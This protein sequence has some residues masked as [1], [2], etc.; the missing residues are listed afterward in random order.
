MA[1]TH[2]VPKGTAS[3]AQFAN[4]SVGEIFVMEGNNN[5]VLSVNQ[6]GN[7]C[8][9]ANCYKLLN[10]QGG[11]MEAIATQLLQ[12]V[13]NNFDMIVVWTTFEDAGGGAFY[14]PLKNDTYGLGKCNQGGGQDQIFGCEFDQVGPQIRAQGLIFMNAVE[15]WKYADS[16]Y[17]LN[18]DE[19]DFRS[20]I[21][22][23][24]GQE[25]AH[26]W[27]VGFH[28]NDPRTGRDSRALL[29]RDFS[30]WNLKLDAFASV[31]DGLDWEDTG[32]GA[33]QIVADNDTY[34]PLDLYAM[35]LM[36]SAE[37]PDFFLV[38]NAF[39]QDLRQMY[40]NFGQNFDGNIPNGNDE[41][42]LPPLE[43]VGRPIEAVGDKL[44]V[45]IQ[46]IVESNGVR[47]PD[48]NSSQKTF[49]QAFVLV[50][51][52]G[53]SVAAAAPY[54][55]QLETVR[56]TWEAWFS[57][58]TGG[59]GTMC[60]TLSGECDTPQAEIRD[61]RLADDNGEWARGEEVELFLSLANTGARSILTVSAALGSNGG[62][63][64]SQAGIQLTDIPGNA[65]VE[66][67]TPFRARLDETF[68]C[69][70][71]TV[72]V[73]VTL[74]PVGTDVDGR[75]FTFNVKPCEPVV[76][77]GNGGGGG[78]NPPA[79]GLCACA[80][81]VSG[82]SPWMGVALLGLLVSRRRR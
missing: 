55:A 52:P 81:A 44:N 60:T 31:M 9:G 4:A 74:D 27:L 18:Y 71:S 7:P 20:Q 1:A 25:S 28:I 38:E 45:N 73:R 22:A 51:L 8:T 75:E 54:V 23:T 67:G 78:S 3:T 39:S 72:T 68:D 56:Q 14:A 12:S 61:L 10:N 42:F 82:A 69:A 77:P 79:F 64:I 32:G 26:R 2:K 24:L 30:H 17:Q 76:D 13:G 33:F 48:V 46:M 41:L 62:V 5:L 57:S 15:T 16:Q 63:D 50:T 47:T 21:F 35:G 11:A 34:S 65:Q 80:E 37:V 66:G 43:V 70:Q 40:A 49:N 59:R 19:T 36:G 6:Q 58:K 53:Q 29:G